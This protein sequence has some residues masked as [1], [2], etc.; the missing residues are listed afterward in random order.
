MYTVTTS[1]QDPSPKDSTVPHIATPG[2]SQSF[3][4]LSQAIARTNL[5]NF[6]WISMSGT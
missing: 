3:E 6:L 4:G 2:I 1:Q 5:K